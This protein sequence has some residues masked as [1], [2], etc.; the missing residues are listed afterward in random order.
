MQ[1][2]FKNIVLAILK[3][4]KKYIKN[5][6]NI[7]CCIYIYL[8]YGLNQTGIFGAAATEREWMGEDAVE[9]PSDSRGKG[10]SEWSTAACTGQTRSNVIILNELLKFRCLYSNLAYI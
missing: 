8:L 6:K 10:S 3:Y 1:I 4:I 7:A 5:I 2:Y 9:G